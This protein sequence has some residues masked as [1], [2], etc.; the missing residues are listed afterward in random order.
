MPVRPKTL[1]PA[2][3][4]PATLSTITISATCT[5]PIMKNAIAALGSIIPGVSV[6]LR[7]TGTDSSSIS[8]PPS[9]ANSGAKA[10]MT[11]P[12]SQPVN[13][14]RV[15]G[16]SAMTTKIG[17]SASST[18]SAILQVA[19]TPTVPSSSKVAPNHS[20]PGGEKV[21]AVASAA[22]SLETWISAAKTMS[23]FWAKT[24]VADPVVPIRIPASSFGVPI[25]MFQT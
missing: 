11:T 21:E 17:P 8:V 13:R 14:P 19:R 4:V 18:A 1:Q 16:N 5:A 12:L 15:A 24:S 23:I 7:R 9:T 3:I 2:T 10:S 6:S 20:R 25:A 22:V